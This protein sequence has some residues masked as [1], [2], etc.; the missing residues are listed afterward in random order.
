MVR[1]AN[2]NP[3]PNPTLTVLGGDAVVGEVREAVGHV[4]SVVRHRRGTEHAL[5]VEVDVILR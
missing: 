3:N 5:A 2:P 1:C 4:G